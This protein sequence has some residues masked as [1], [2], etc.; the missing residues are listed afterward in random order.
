MHKKD[1]NMSIVM[2]GSGG[3]GKSC[4]TIRFVVNKFTDEYDATI[5]D[6]YQKS[7]IVDDTISHIE[8]VDTAGQEEFQS[9]LDSWIRASE[10]IILVYDVSNRQ[11]FEELSYFYDKI[12]E[13]KDKTFPL[14]L[15]GNKCDLPPEKHIISTLRGQALAAEWKC[16]FMEVSAKEKINDQLCFIE[17][18]REVRRI[19]NLNEPVQPTKNNFLFQCFQYFQCFQC[20]FG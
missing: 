14:L 5:E 10:G 16:L 6:A 4:L 3:V 2:L 17:I 12:I 7:V 1:E 8:I 11:S 15:V 19:R 13:T 18:I 20:F 9:M